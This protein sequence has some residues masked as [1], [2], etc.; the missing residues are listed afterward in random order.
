MRE[1]PI[2]SLD[3]YPKPGDEQYLLEAYRCEDIQQI[4]GDWRFCSNCS[5]DERTVLRGRLESIYNSRCL[6][7]KQ[8]S[9]TPIRGSI[10]IENILFD[11]NSDVI[12]PE[13]FIIIDK[14]SA[15]LKRFPTMEI[16]IGGHTDSRGGADQNQAL[17]QRR[18]DSV[19]RALIEKGIDGTRM[20][21]VGYGEYKPLYTNSTDEGRRANRRTEIKILKQ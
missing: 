11:T 17:S 4:L 7:V 15:Q 20:V 3:L 12:K 10:N 19:K 1:N 5:E 13:S 14:L 8:T 21:A 16:E 6:D 18:S 2:L 9:T